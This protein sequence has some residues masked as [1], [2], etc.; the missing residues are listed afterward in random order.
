MIEKSVYEDYEI[1][2]SETYKSDDAYYFIFNENRELY[3]NNDKTLPTNLGNVNVNFK[4][5]YSTVYMLSD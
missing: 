4:Y 3:L 2:F 1:D 5:Y